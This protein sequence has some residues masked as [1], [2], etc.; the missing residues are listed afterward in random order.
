M[1]YFAGCLACCLIALSLWGQT[2]SGN[3]RGTITDPSG[4]ALA[5][6][7]VTARNMD[8]GLSI[9]TASTDAGLYS[10]PN[11]PPGRYSVSVE[12]PSPFR[13]DVTR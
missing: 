9:T 8:T 5:G 4:A 7:A 10:V 11:L 13:R 3:I 1:R 12:A 6:A 2:N